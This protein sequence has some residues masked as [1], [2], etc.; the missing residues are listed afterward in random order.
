MPRLFEALIVLENGGW[1]ILSG[2]EVSPLVD[3]AGVFLQ[4]FNHQAATMVMISSWMVLDE[5]L[6]FLVDLQVILLYL[7]TA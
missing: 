2:L 5:K 3:T 7:M 6:N 1:E 4:G